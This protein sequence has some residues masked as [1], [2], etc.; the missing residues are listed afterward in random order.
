[1]HS[2]CIMSCIHHSILLG[3]QLALRPTDKKTELQQQIILG[4]ALVST[5]DHKEVT[6]V[7]YDL[8]LDR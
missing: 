1:M 6:F 2:A 7:Y 5:T 3:R 4:S 8:V